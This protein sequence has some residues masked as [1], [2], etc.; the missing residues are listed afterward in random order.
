MTAPNVG[1]LLPTRALLMQPEAPREQGQGRSHDQG[2]GESGEVDERPS[3]SGHSSR[4]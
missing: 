1:I 2:E 4:E 3:H